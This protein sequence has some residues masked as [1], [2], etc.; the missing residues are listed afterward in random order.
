M[1]QENLEENSEV[2]WTRDGHSIQTH[3]TRPLSNTAWFD[4][5]L[6]DQIWRNLIWHNLKF[7]LISYT[8]SQ[9][10]WWIYFLA[11]ARKQSYILHLYYDMT[12]P[13]L[14]WHVMTLTSLDANWHDLSG[15]LSPSKLHHQSENKNYQ[16]S[17]LSS[18]VSVLFVC[19]LH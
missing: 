18:F 16:I 2:E 14:T 3:Q 8:C 17:L 9:E 5:A 10:F 6:S 19:L 1:L 12:W 11:W 4:T 13:M 7:Y 15:I